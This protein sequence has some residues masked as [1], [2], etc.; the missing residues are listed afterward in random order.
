LLSLA[1][2]W[3]AEAGSFV[4]ETAPLLEVRQLWPR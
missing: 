2:E 4:L 3:D 1:L